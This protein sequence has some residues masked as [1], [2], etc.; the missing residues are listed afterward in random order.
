MKIITIF[1]LSLSVV[2]LTSC[3]DDEEPNVREDNRIS[4]STGVKKVSKK[5]VVKLSALPSERIQA[6]QRPNLDVLPSVGVD[7]LQY[8]TEIADRKRNDWIN[9]DFSIPP[10]AL[11]KPIKPKYQAPVDSLRKQEFETTEEFD[12]RVAKMHNVQE[13]EAQ[14]IDLEYQNRL[15]KYNSKLNEYDLY[16]E[17]E[18]E[19]RLKASKDIFTAYVKEGVDNM[20]GTPSVK[21]LVYSADLESFYGT[22][23]SKI[24]SFNRRIVI[25][26]PIRIA[27]DF[28]DNTQYALPD[29]DFALKEDNTLYIEK[30]SI[31]FKGM[32][33]PASIV[34]NVLSVAKSKK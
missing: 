33:Y 12:S 1:T 30:L 6:Y 9:R 8:I 5:P 16:I 31:I 3:A 15:Y 32:T 23:Y 18:K 29:I 25:N 4:I 17:N 14:K 10:F 13:E 28:K 2:F 26:V 22:L 21:E 34:R 11:L 20:L 24:S 7:I 27:H 19:Q